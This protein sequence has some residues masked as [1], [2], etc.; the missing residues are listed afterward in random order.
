MPSRGRSYRIDEYAKKKDI[1]NAYISRNLS[2]F[3]AAKGRVYHGRGVVQRSW[4]HKL[5]ELRLK[6]A[7]GSL[8]SGRGLT[9]CGFP[10]AD[11]VP[12]TCEICL[13]STFPAPIFGS[14]PVIFTKVRSKWTR[15]LSSRGRYSQ[16]FFHLGDKRKYD[17]KAG[18]QNIEKIGNRV[19]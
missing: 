3:K 5:N 12:S 18:G 8:K 7:G 1:A 9:C 10:D 19:F 16:G 14:L 17:K 4:G 11:I 6:S 15:E 13:D 2:S